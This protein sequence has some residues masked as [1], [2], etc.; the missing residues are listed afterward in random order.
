[1]DIAFGIRQEKWLY[2]FFKL[3]EK[4]VL[5]WEF[6]IAGAQYFWM[7][8]KSQPAIFYQ[9]ALSPSVVTLKFKTFFI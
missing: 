9:F 6:Q 1:M 5:F 8:L 4:M 7:Y 2:P 3:L